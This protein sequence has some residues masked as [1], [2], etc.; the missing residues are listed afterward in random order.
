[1]TRLRPA[2]FWFVPLLMWWM[3]GD[4]CAATNVLI[5]GATNA[6]AIAGNAPAPGLG[7]VF[8][9]T[10]GALL[11]VL[12]L[13]LG[14]AWF[15]RRSRLFGLVSTKGSHLRVIESRSLGARHSLHVVEYGDQRFL[16]A[17]TPAGTNLIAPVNAPQT[18][19]IAETAGAAG[20]FGEKLRAIL[21]GKK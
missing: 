7:E 6:P 12:A 19:V 15:F 13:L 16:I 18:P 2:L 11:M 20:S 4:L 14:A 9:R 10:L 5:Y 3:A 8:I 1:M 21:E 17:D